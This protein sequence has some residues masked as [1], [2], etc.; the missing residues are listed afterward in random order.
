VDSIVIVQFLGRFQYHGGQ[1]QGVR[2]ALEAHVGGCWIAV[3][4]AAQ[5]C[6]TGEDLVPVALDA[7]GRPVVRLC[8]AYD[9]LRAGN[10]IEPTF[11]IIVNHQE[12]QS[13]QRC[14]A[15]KC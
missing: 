6:I 5:R 12:A 15:C 13:G 9:F 10:V 3:G 11:C 1:D 8:S 7:D 4:A 14:S 2:S